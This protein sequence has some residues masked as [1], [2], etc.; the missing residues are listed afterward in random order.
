METSRSVGASVPSARC[1]QRCGIGDGVYG[2]FKS[3][4]H[5]G[6]CRVEQP[7]GSLG[8]FKEKVVLN[9]NDWS[10]F[11]GF[12]TEATPTEPRPLLFLHPFRLRHLTDGS[13]RLR[14]AETAARPWRPLIF[15][16][17]GL[18]SVQ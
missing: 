9:D 16:V 2:V 12:L 13:D 3:H 6:I 1:L 8:N 7:V 14:A 17:N 4:V 10:S 11:G 15:R 5:F 18:G